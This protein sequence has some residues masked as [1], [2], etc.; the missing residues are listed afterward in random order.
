LRKGIAE[1]VKHKPKVLEPGSGDDDEEDESL[2]TQEQIGLWNVNLFFNYPIFFQPTNV[3][4]RRSA[5][6]TTTRVPI[7]GR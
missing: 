5:N 7:C 6:S 2:L 1:G 3:I 4:S